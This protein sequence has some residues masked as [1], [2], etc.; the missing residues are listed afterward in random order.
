[1]N[2]LHIV[3]GGIE[4]GDK[5]WLERAAKRKWTANQWTTPKA[6]EIGDQVVIYI[7]GIGFFATGKVTSTPRPDSGRPGRYSAGVTSIRLIDPPISLSAITRAIPDLTWTVYPRSYTTPSSRIAN[8]IKKLISVRRTTR[9]PNL[10]L[11]TLEEANL[12]ELRKLA[13][14]SARTRVPGKTARTIY[15][16]RSAAIRHYV[17][18]RA[19]GDCEGCGRPAPFRNGKGAP[20]LE[21]HHTTR[22]SD[23]GPDHPA[24]VIALCPNCHRRAHYSQE[25]ASFNS[26][27]KK[28]LARLER[29]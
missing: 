14:M 11:E 13:L 24:R 15:R 3:Q 6:A 26:S 20:Y 4:N 2:M 16:E 19:D 17:L 23:E 21:P 1:M 22:L 8:K 9:L 12:Q 10:N 5:N 29:I 27:L 7:G 18:R 28:R 25:S